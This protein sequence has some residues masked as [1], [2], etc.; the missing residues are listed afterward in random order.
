MKLNVGRPDQIIR[1]ILGLVL[2][3]VGIYTGLWWLYIIAAILIVTGI[4]GFCLIYR[5]IGKGTR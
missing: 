3:S 1:V 5:L 2:V 4:T